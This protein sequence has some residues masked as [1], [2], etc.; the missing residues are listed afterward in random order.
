MTFK[1]VFRSSEIV[2]VWRDDLETEFARIRAI[3]SKYN[4]ISMDTEFPG[5]VARPLGNFTSQAEFVYQQLRCNV[6][7][8]KIIQLGLT[9]MDENGNK[10]SPCTWQFNFLFDV[11]NDMCANDSLNLLLEADLDFKKHKEKGIEASMFGEFLMTSGLVLTDEIVWISFHSSYDFGY[12]IKILTGTY[13]PEETSDFLD[14]VDIFFKTYYDLKHLLSGGQF[15]KSGLQEIA[16]SLDIQRLGT[17]HQAG[18]DSLLTA[19]LFIKLKNMSIIDLEV[20]INRNRLF[21]V[22]RKFKPQENNESNL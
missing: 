3:R 21:G 13:L 6:N 5:V 19:M 17:A 12:V 14:L 18:S 9:F 22:A 11:D 10:P 1:R 20:E 8:L 16:D 15:L 7:L 4:F 2:D